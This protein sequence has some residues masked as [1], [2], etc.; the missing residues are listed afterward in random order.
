[1]HKVVTHGLMVAGILSL[2][3]ACSGSSDT[4]TGDGSG[5]GGSTAGTGGD[6][7]SAGTGGAAGSAGSGG[8]TE[9]GGAGGGATGG[10]GGSATGGSG[11]GTGGSATGG[12]GGSTA[13]FWPAA[14]DTSGTSNPSSGM[15][16]A[17]KVCGNCHTGG[18]APA[19]SFAGTVYQADG[20]TGA[21]H[22]EVG[23]Q[24]N[25]TTYTTYSGQNGNFFL[26][27]G[28]TIDFAQADVRMRNGNGEV[29]MSMGAGGRWCNSCHTGGNKL[30]EP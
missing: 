24:V 28:T 5:A 14:Y 27:P 16:N 4:T 29:A 9:T 2:L 21:Q 13:A 7:G 8:T 1:M 17:G 11:G 25:G 20:T 12:A 18:D 3:A 6:A 15:H 26:A 10:S 23:V 30:I 19:W 22:V